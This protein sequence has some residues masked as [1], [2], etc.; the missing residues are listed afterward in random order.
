MPGHYNCDE[1]SIDG[2][3]ITVDNKFKEVTLCLMEDI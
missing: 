2:L 3:R 1:F